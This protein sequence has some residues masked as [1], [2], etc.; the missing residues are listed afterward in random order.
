MEILFPYLFGDVET[1]IDVTDVTLYDSRLSA[2][3][4]SLVWRLTHLVEQ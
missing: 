3:G 2:E 1:Q 4:P